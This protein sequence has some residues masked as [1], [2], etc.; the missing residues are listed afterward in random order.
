MDHIRILFENKDV[1][2]IHKPAGVLVHVFSHQKS[3][4]GPTVVQWALEH[5]PEMKDVGDDTQ[6]RPGV[7][8][9]LD[10]ETSGVLLLARNQ[11]AF[12]Y[13]K[14]VF[15]KHEIQKTY[16]AIVCGVPK[17]KK[18]T[19][20]YSIG[21]KK[22]T[23]KRSIHGTKSRKEAIT[24]YEVVET[25]EKNGSAYSL[26]KIYPKTGRTHQIRIHMNAMHTPVVGD[27]MYGGKKNAELAQRHMLHCVSL[28]FR[29]QDGTLLKIDDPVPE[30]FTQFKTLTK[31]A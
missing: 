7:V 26:V 29:L 27:K 19:I 11:K 25:F 16:L 12:T 31:S 8:H 22:G 2:A 30:E 28:E 15:Q 1:V 14:S 6:Y 4:K 23:T 20:E 18:G 24:D 9:R 13:I 17:D 10:R 5:F 21:I 3:E